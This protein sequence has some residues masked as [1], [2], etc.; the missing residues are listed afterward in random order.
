MTQRFD[1]TRAI[2]FDLARGQLRDAEG[3]RRFNLPIELVM[4]L[5]RQ[6]PDEVR[7]DFAQGLGSDL[8][9]RVSES[10]GSEARSASV[11]VWTEHLG[12]QIALMGLG[13][14]RVERWG[15]G[16]VLRLEG[17]ASETFELVRN[18]LIGALQRALGHDVALVAFEEEQSVAFL[19]LSEQSALKAEA[20]VQQGETLA[21]VVESLHQGAA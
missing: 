12:G 1:P 6:A 20:L 21:R 18:L 15:K 7:Q 11:E 13:N 3:A 5:Y 14:L 17:V 4:R 8:G 10:L 16:L 9:R 19:V 2:V